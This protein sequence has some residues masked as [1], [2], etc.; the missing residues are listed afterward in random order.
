MYDSRKKGERAADVV[1]EQS[2]PGRRDHGFGA[3]FFNLRKAEERD[4]V[5]RRFAYEYGDC[6]EKV[7][8]AEFGPEEWSTLC[9]DDMQRVAFCGNSNKTEVWL[10]VNGMIRL[11]EKKRPARRDAKVDHHTEEIDALWAEAEANRA[12]T[13]AC[14]RGGTVE[15]VIKEGDRVRKEILSGVRS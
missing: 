12:M 6:S 15:E 9:K 7:F 5:T 10:L 8:R 14:C 1:K 4:I 3:A 2:T 13:I 11:L